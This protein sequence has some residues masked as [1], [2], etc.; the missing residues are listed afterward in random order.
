MTT[1]EVEES[2]DM[3][4][5]ASPTDGNKNKAANSIEIMNDASPNNLRSSLV[6]LWKFTI[7][8]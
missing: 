8:I 2:K 7:R 3:Q 4:I 1:I 5:V 6:C